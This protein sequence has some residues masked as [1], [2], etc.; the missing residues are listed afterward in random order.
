LEITADSYKWFL[1]EVYE[2]NDFESQGISRAY[3]LKEYM[4][5]ELEA[6]LT[7]KLQ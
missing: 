6:L 5:A 4:K 1:T 7:R 2:K 3:A